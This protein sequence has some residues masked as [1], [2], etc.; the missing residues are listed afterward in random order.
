MSSRQKV[1]AAKFRRGEISRGSIRRGKVS[2]RRNFSR[3]YWSQRSLVAARFR[4]GSIGRGEVSSRQT[5]ARPVPGGQNCLSTPDVLP[6]LVT[7]H[8]PLHAASSVA[9]L[10]TALPSSA[11][12]LEPP[13]RDYTELLPASPHG[14]RYILYIQS[15]PNH[16][17]VPSHLSPTRL[18]GPPACTRNKL[19]GNTSRP[20]FQVSARPVFTRL[21]VA[22]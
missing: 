6:D 15:P 8:T 21:D 19:Q 1:V 2:T 13:T 4:R 16:V 3:Q 9:S 5:F 14:H 10:W 18:S 11:D 7:G 22:L 20:C 17:H 12:C